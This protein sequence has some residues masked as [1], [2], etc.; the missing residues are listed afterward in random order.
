MA[1]VA[2]LIGVCPL[3]ACPFCTALKPT[4]CER[5]ETAAVAALAEFVAA[6]GETKTFRVHQALVGKQQIAGKDELRIAVDWQG[7]AGALAMLFAE[8]DA[9]ATLD[10]LEWSAVGVNETSFAYIAR[11]PS[12]RTKAAERLAYFVPFLQ[13]ADALIADDVYQEFG[14]APLSDVAKI[15]DH[16]PFDKLRR[17]LLDRE[18]PQERKGFFGVA[19]GL[20]TTD[21]DRRANLATLEKVMDSDENDFRAGFDGVLGGY[22]LLRGEKGLAEVAR[23]YFADAKTAEGDTR[24]AISAVRFFYEYDDASDRERFREAL[25][26]L[27]DRPPF[28][29]AAAIDLARWKDWAS[30]AKVAKLYD[31]AD[32]PQP[33]TREA[34]VA[35][36]LAC[37]E[38]AAAKA[39]AE[40]RTR[41][42][43][44]VAAAELKLGPIASPRQ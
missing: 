31:A 12:L 11:A 19:L 32:Y 39:L 22:L 42:P 44:G 23:R 6:D 13:H 28:A 24:H 4:L 34:A 18:I 27:L 20:A 8:G 33:S 1:A 16:L 36:L 15:A 14:H 26:P 2:L 5:R 29:S 21:A 7:K 17:W 35:Y 25:R 10:K 41:D 43:K 40:I 38:D 37:P 9:A 30:L 3:R